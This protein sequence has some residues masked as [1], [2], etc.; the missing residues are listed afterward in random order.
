MAQKKVIWPFFFI[1]LLCSVTNH[2]S[3]VPFSPFLAI[4]S[5]YR[6]RT[7]V[8]WVSMACGLIMD[9]FSSS[10]F[11]IYAFSYALTSSI[12]FRYRIYF[13]EKPIGF[14]IFTSIFSL[15]STIAIR[16]FLIFDKVSLPMSWKSFIIDFLVMPFLDGV[17][18]FLFFSIP[19][20]LYRL[21][22]KHWFLFLFFR[23][24]TKKKKEK[25]LKTYVK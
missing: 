5:Y 10:S 19:L 20:I 14:S 24:E 3:L 8:L 9:V 16:F 7:N 15:L 11:G 21:I 6:P 22:H 25:E 2:W 1:S 4:T 18:S 13:L 17:Y 12:L 23:K